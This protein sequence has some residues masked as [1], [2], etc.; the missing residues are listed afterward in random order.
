MCSAVLTSTAHLKP[1]RNGS[2]FYQ[3]APPSTGD[4]CDPE[5]PGTP[6]AGGVYSCQPTG[7]WAV[8]SPGWTPQARIAKAQ[9]GDTVMI[10][11]CSGFVRHVVSA[12]VPHQLYT[13]VGLMTQNY[14]EL[15]H[16]TGE[17]AYI[18]NHVV[19]LKNRI[20]E[21]ALRYLWPGTITESI[22]E[23]FDSGRDLTGPD[24][25]GYA[26]VKGFAP[27]EVRCPNEQDIVF[28]RILKP[29]PDVENQ[30]RPILHVAA[31]K[32]RAIFGHYRFG[33]YSSAQDTAQDDPNAP[34]PIDDTAKGDKLFGRV[35]T[36]CSSFVR[37]A[38][39][40]AGADLDKDKQLPTPTDMTKT[41]PEGL[42]YY[43]ADERL[44]AGHQLYS[45]VYNAVQ[46]QGAQIVA[47]DY[48]DSAKWW[49]TGIAGG[50]LAG[51]GICFAW[52]GPTAAA[53][54][55]L[56]GSALGFLGV[57]NLGPL[58]KFA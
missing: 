6:P 11:S 38:L 18:G 46:T 39:K 2:G 29:A 52:A 12:L 36:V 44:N 43:H 47:H 4:V 34:A 8:A 7:E 35:P 53:G 25:L 26:R 54:C 10:R 32:S 15:R 24:G 33:Q 28:P 51:A 41:S 45:A 56:I 23:A 5:N 50:G 30:V 48:T 37:L 19:G 42:M 20:E 58:S 13:H 16:S 49:A 17:S 22:E 3:A 9:K 14:V 31:D 55:G 1:Y 21:N 57:A 40:A 27:G